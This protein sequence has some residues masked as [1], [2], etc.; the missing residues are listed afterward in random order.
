MQTI[1]IVRVI[2]RRRIILNSG[3]VI[4]WLLVGK[5]SVIAFVIR[6]RV[7]GLFGVGLGGSDH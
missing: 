1:F 6:C 7:S 4:L 5:N 2:I 3:E